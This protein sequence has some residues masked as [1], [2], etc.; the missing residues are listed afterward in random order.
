MKVI[1]IW[2]YTYEDWYNYIKSHNGA[3]TNSDIVTLVFVY[4]MVA[5]QNLPFIFLTVCLSIVFH[6]YLPY[7]NNEP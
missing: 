6:P 2:K 3:L 5:H 1:G 4:V 7:P